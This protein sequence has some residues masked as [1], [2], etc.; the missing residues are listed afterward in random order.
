MK[1]LFGLQNCIEFVLQAQILKDECEIVSQ[2]VMPISSGRI[3][4]LFSRLIFFLMFRAYTDSEIL[5]PLMK[6]ICK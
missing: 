4:T 2:K 5:H 1:I 6:G 3:L